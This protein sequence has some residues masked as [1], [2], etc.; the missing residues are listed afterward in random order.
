MLWLW[1]PPIINAATF[2]W[3]NTFI[4]IA[5]SSLRGPVVDAFL[6]RLASIEENRYSIVTQFQRGKPCAS[7]ATEKA[8][9][10]ESF[11]GQLSFEAL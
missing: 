2:S 6:V 9:P 7:P 8:L 1:P 10:W 11:W 3:H 5:R 4:L